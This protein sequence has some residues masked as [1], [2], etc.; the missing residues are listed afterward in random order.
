[1]RKLKPVVD[2]DWRLIGPN[3]DMR[4]LIPGAE[5]FQEQWEAGGKEKEHNAAVD[6]HFFRGSDGTYHL[7][8]CIRNT[9]VGRVL[10]R[11]E[12]DD[13]D[14]APWRQT[15]EIIRCDHDAG[16]CI[17]DWGGKEWLQSPYFIHVDGTYY[18]FFGGHNSDRREDGSEIP[19]DIQ[20]EERHVRAACQMCLMTSPDGRTWTRHRNAEGL[21]RLFAGPG[22]VRDPCLLGVGDEW[23]CYYAG[24]SNND[25]TQHGFY[26]RTSKDLV[27]WSD[28]KMIHQDLNRASGNWTTE[29]PHVV[30]RDG[31]YYLFRTENYYAKR[32][33]VFRSEDPFDFGVG[34]AS[35]KFVC[36]FPAAA[37]EIYEIEGREYVTSSHDPKQGEFMARLKWVDD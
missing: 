9:V 36:L 29:C 12:T 4:G 17:N 18:M 15:G 25:R 10:Y 3:P 31:Y 23:V 27:T 14:A 28:Y 6:H 37:V 7:W 20:G 30:F 19:D 32:T 34:D 22:E 13:I 26:A 8:G 5:E 16:E 1:M 24:F 21:S 33:H 35:D 2:G 11:W